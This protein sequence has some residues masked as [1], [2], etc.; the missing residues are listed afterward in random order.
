MVFIPFF[1][2]CV[3]VYATDECQSLTT[4]RKYA[5]HSGISAAQKNKYA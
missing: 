1:N 2:V 3:C 4:K 5:K